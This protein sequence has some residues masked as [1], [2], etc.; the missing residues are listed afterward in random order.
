M[1]GRLQTEGKVLA[2]L[3]SGANVDPSLFRQILS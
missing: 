2:V 3:A 1:A